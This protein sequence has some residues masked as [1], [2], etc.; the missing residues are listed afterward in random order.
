LLERP[1]PARP[2]VTGADLQGLGLRPGPHFKGLMDAVDVEVLERRIHDKAEALAF[3]QARL[4][5]TGE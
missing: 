5:A 4:G 1:L 2:L 3:V